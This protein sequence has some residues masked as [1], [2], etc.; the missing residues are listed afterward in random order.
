MSDRYT[1]YDAAYVLGALSPEER[2]EFEAHLQTCDECTKSVHEMADLPALLRSLPAAAL[3]DTAE[4]SAVPPPTLLPRLLWAVQ[5]ERKRRRWVVGAIGGLAAACVVALAVLLGTVV[6]SGS[7]SGRGVAMSQMTTTPIHATA[8]LT[9]VAAGTRIMLRCTYD[10]TS[11]YQASEAYQLVIVPYNGAPERVSSWL[12]V[13][14]RETDVSA[15]TK[16]K[17]SAISAIQIAP[18]NEPPVLQLRL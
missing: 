9:D 10:M 2:A 13:A 3:E 1:T 16:L 6:F 17:R 14:G 11:A 18:V 4:E 5:G 12:T 7:S 8:Q 15:L